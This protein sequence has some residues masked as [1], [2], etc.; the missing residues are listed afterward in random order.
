MPQSA[1][2]AY[3]LLND[4][5]SYAGNWNERVVDEVGQRR[6]VSH[7]Q[8]DNNNNNNNNNQVLFFFFPFTFFISTILTDGQSSATRLQ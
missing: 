7:V 2:F 4:H 8:N 1:E 3:R 5:K 6:D